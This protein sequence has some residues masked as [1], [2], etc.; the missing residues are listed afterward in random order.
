MNQEILGYK[1]GKAPTFYQRAC[2]LLFQKAR[3]QLVSAT[4]VIDK[5]GDKKFRYELM[6]FLRH[7]IAG[8]TRLIKKIKME[9]S[10][11]NNL[12]QL[13][14]YIAGVVHVSVRRKGKHHQKYYQLIRG[15]EC[16]HE[17]YVI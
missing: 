2:E 4:V 6:T 13:A 1:L 17:V 15:K 8:H 14:D 12:L 3:N 11:H 10:D 16:C 9:K 7:H 5:S